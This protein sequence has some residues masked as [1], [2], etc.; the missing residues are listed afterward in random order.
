MKFIAELTEEEMKALIELRELKDG[1][2]SFEGFCYVIKNEYI[3]K[4]IFPK[5]DVKDFIDEDLKLEV[6][7]LT[8]LNKALLK[9]NRKVNDSNSRLELVL[10]IAGLFMVLFVIVFCSIVG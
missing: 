4:I 8:Q 5:G 6:A 9:K 7:S 2:K 3:D 10:V 1:K